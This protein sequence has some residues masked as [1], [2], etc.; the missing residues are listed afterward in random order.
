MEHPV[1]NPK[2]IAEVTGVGKGTYTEIIAIIAPSSAYAGNTV[3]VEVQIKNIYSGWVHI[4]CIGV[5]D[6]TNRFIDWLDVWVAPGSTQSFY[7]SF[8][9]PNMGVTVNAYSY[10]EAVD[11]YL[12]FDDSKS[13]SISLATVGPP[14]FSSFLITDYSR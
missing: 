7:G 13:Q 5:L 12:Y 8:V 6:T 10:Y 14:Q 9:M 1:G 11:G 3:N 2:P 4:Y